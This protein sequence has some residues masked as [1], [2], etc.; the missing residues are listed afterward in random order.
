MAI[1]DLLAS[2]ADEVKSG[3]AAGAF[4]TL[5]WDGEPVVVR[6]VEV[7]TSCS[8]A[9]VLRLSRSSEPRR[10]S[11]QYSIDRKRESTRSPVLFLGNP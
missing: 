9:R 11:L 2:A 6:E 7:R 1:E 5:D 4:D 10:K 3:E 8:S